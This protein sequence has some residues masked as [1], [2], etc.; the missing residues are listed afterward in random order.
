MLLGRGALAGLGRADLGRIGRAVAGGLGLSAGALAREPVLVGVDDVALGVLGAGDLGV[1]VV[2]R[3]LQAVL[4][5]HVRLPAQDL[6][7]EEMFFFQVE[8]Y[9]YGCGNMVQ[10]GVANPILGRVS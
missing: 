10:I 7:K 2:D 5:V 1:E 3:L 4:Q 9:N 6:E 8:G